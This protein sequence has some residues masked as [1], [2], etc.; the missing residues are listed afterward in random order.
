MSLEMLLLGF[1]R[2]PQTGYDLRD[3]F[4][5]DVPSFWSAELSQIY[6]ALSRLE[7][8]GLLK[9]RRQRS[10][11]GPARKVYRTTAKGHRALARWIEQGPVI[12]AE[13]FAYLAQLMHMD[14]LKDPQK[15]LDFLEQLKIE[16]TTWRKGL[17]AIQKEGFG[18]DKI[19]PLMDDEAFYAYSTLTFGI[20]TMQA[21]LRWVN[22]TIKRLRTRMAAP[23]DGLE[24][25]DA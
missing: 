9:S 19:W 2:T 24:D 25:C 1:M 13:R 16:L 6:P 20:D 10:V 18:G 21:K 11:K 8:E 5:G 22:K 12:G 14:E 23:G 17:K 3:F 15:A 4:A 7:K